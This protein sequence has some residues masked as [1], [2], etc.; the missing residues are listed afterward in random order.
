MIH[1]DLKLDLDDIPELMEMEVMDGQI[2]G[3]FMEMDEMD[4]LP[5]LPP[6]YSP[7]N[8]LEKTYAEYA[9]FCHRCMMNLEEPNIIRQKHFSGGCVL[10]LSPSHLLILESFIQRMDKLEIAKLKLRSFRSE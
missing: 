8:E 2:I 1:D 9:V 5:F 10:T 7:E 3:N 4:N 6:D